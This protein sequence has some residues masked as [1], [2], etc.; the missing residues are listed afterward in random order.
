MDKILFQNK[1]LPDSP[2]NGRAGRLKTPN[3]GVLCRKC[4][5]GQQGGVGDQAQG[6]EAAEQGLADFVAEQG[7]AQHPPGGAPQ[8]GTAQQRRLRDAAAVELGHQ[9][10][11]SEEDEGQNA[12]DA[13]PN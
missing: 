9:L 12:G 10:V 8:E 6:D 5:P 4:R 1:N 13:Q 3:D 11:P 7:H 2:G